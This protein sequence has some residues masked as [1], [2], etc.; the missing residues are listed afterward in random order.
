MSASAAAMAPRAPERCADD[1]GGAEAGSSRLRPLPVERSALR[2]SGAAG[3]GRNVE[4]LPAAC[5]EAS[6]AALFAA[7]GLLVAGADR[8][9]PAASKTG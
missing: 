7:D 5:A 6:A 1:G 2:A 9:L 4:V 3:H 8:P